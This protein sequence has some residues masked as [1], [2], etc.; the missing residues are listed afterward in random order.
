M[1]TDSE[2]ATATTSDTGVSQGPRFLML[3]FVV[4]A[5]VTVTYSIDI[6]PV[7]GP[8]VVKS[9]GTNAAVIDL[10]GTLLL[11]AA[12]G[13]VMLIGQAGD[14]FSH[15]P[16]FLYVGC[17]LTIIGGLLASFPPDGAVLILGRLLIGIG[18]VGMAVPCIAF[19]N[20]KFPVGDP[21]RGLAFGL[22]ASGFGLG[23]VIA[24]IIGGLLGDVENGWRIAGLMIPLFGLICLIGIAATVKG[25]PG[26]S[27]DAKLDIVGSLLLLGAMAGLI[28]AL[29][30]APTY[31]WLMETKPFTFELWTWP[32]D[33]SMPFV[34]GVIS[35]LLWIIFGLYERKRNATGK[36]AVLDFSLFE[37]RSFRIGLVGCFLFFLGS[38]AAILVIPQFFLFSLGFDTITLGLSLLPIGIGIVVFGYLAGPIGN[39]YGARAAVLAGFI[40]ITVGS[41]AV[42]P[43]MNPNSNGWQTAIP[44]LIFGI[45]FGLVYARITQTVLATVPPAKAGLGGAT[46][47]G[48]RLLGGAFGAVI[49]TVVMV[50]TAAD[51][52][53]DEIASQ[54]ANLST[55]QVDELTSLVERG[56]ALRQEAGGMNQLAGDRSYQEVLQKEELKPAI[57]DI[58]DS[59]SFA[60]RITMII[61]ALIAVLGIIITLRLPKPKSG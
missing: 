10:G 25:E 19:L 39:K 58:A 35:V 17:G 11:A 30:E 26:Q 41:L 44:L 31:G 6:L 2:A 23:F 22:F 33:I 9:I 36:A 18:A 1:P 40:A 42:I 52:A 48:I 24:P 57:G 12:G 49:L 46:M 37:S 16:I 34:L 50:T 55:Q 28:V 54:K 45:G 29:N 27:P 8:E 59:Y 7:I 38:F 60:F 15:K 56:A 61:V 51:K 3:A 4:L 20:L 32:L 43:F 53:Q 14:K 13:F 21:A 47:F 5:V